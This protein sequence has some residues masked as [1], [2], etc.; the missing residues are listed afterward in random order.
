M[1]VQ[2]VYSMLKSRASVSN[3]GPAILALG[4]SPLTYSAL[5]AQI[6]NVVL[7]LKRAGI[8]RGDRVVTVLKN[9]PE[10]AVCCLAVCSGAVCAPLNPECSSA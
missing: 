9:G 6:E 5:L 1:A 3:G 8:G 7:F 2:S 10:A 4:R